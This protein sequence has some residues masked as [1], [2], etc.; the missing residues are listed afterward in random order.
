MSKRFS[1]PIAGDP[2]T[3]L[4]RARAA[5][6]QAGVTLAGDAAAGTFEGSGVEGSYAVDGGTIVVTVE[7]KPFIAPWGMVERTL[8]DF[9]SG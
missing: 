9:F 5:A 2:E 4:E 6:A 3:L 7:R 8:R 1:F